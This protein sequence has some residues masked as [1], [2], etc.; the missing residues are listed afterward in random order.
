MVSKFRAVPVRNRTTTPTPILRIRPDAADGMV[1]EVQGV[2]GFTRQ[3]EI[4]PDS[5]W[6]GAARLW[7]DL[8]RNRAPLLGVLRHLLADEVG[9]LPRVLAIKQHLVLPVPVGYRLTFYA[10]AAPWRNLLF[11]G[12][13]HGR[14]GFVLALRGCEFAQP[15]LVLFPHLLENRQ[16]NLGNHVVPLEL[17]HDLLGEKF[18]FFVCKLH[19]S[20]LSPV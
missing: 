5:E 18:D 19:Y 16:R 2:G 20:S 3:G 4:V 13:L 15:L 7:A 11:F 14:R 17:L 6:R 10:P 12:A 9:K 8:A 1:H